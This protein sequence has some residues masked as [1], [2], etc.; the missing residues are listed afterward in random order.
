M[1][2]VVPALAAWA[3]FRV[4]IL[5]AR[6]AVPVEANSPPSIQPPSAMPVP[7]A[8][9]TISGESTGGRGEVGRGADAA[10]GMSA[11]AIV[12]MVWGA[13]ALGILAALA[14]AGFSVRRITRRARPLIS[15]EWQGPLFEIADRIGLDDAPR[16]LQSDDAKMPFACGVLT[17]TIV[18]PAEAESWT[19]DRRRTVLLHE[20]AHV[21]RRD[22]LGHALGRLTCA[23]YWFHPLVWTAAKQLRAE[24]ERACDD[25]ALSLRNACDRLR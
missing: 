6:S 22:L 15:A 5:P 1:L 11:L 18:L 16:L 8:S 21:R 19:L 10:G 13:V 23:V 14:W 25:L 7:P 3:P 9:V 2:L 20:L 4:A 24:S 12:A 17:P